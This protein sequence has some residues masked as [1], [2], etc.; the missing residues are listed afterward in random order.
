L[1]YSVADPLLVLPARALVA[2]AR[3]VGEAGTRLTRYCHVKRRGSHANTPCRRFIGVADLA[4][5][6]FSLPSQLLEP[7]PN[8]EYWNYL[9][10][11]NAFVA[12]GTA[13]DPVDRM[14][15]VLRFWFTKDL[16][17][18]KGK[19]C[20]PYNSCLGEFFRVGRSQHHGGRPEYSEILME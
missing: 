9:D 18:A 12:I 5:V 4:S 1:G 20:K 19:P 2:A 11:P 17:Y 16:K 8:L 15:E 10:S 6:R 13:D 3:I 7:T 14:L